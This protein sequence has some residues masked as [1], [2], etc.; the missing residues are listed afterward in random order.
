[1]LGG[2][3][4]SIKPSTTRPI[5]VGRVSACSKRSNRQ[6]HAPTRNPCVCLS[7]LVW[8]ARWRDRERE[9]ERER[10]RKDSQKQASR[11][12]RAQRAGCPP[13]QLSHLAM[14]LQAARWCAPALAP[15]VC[16]AVTADMLLT[17]RRHV[18]ECLAACNCPVDG[19]ESPCSGATAQIAYRGLALCLISTVVPRFSKLAPP[20]MS[21][22]HCSPIFQ[23]QCVLT[24]FAAHHQD[25][26]C[27]CMLPLAKLVRSISRKTLLA[28]CASAAS[29]PI[30]RSLSISFRC[31]SCIP[32]LLSCIVVER[33]DTH[34]QVSAF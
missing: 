6:V 10:A 29:L 25:C 17:Q 16:C 14:R 19:S 1:M 21:L 20:W 22:V 28:R 12:G 26:S 9:R 8:P 2:S 34:D 32:S 15:K 23:R 18:A 5:D 31:A 27:T 24:D 11:P 33:G 4:Y 13:P 30:D 3:P 7:S